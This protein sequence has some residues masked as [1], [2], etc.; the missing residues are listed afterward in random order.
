MYAPFASPVNEYAPLE[1]VVVVAEAVP[2]NAT[3][4]PALTGPET[5]PEM[6]SAPASLKSPAATSAFEIVTVRL[7]GVKM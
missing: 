4:T 7:A 1:S 5:D 3:V 6:A 2:P